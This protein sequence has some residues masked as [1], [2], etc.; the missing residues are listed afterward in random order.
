MFKRIRQVLA[1]ISEGQTL[2]ARIFHGGAWLGAGSLSEQTVRFARNVILARLLAPEAFGTMA[3][4]LSA[5]SIFQSFTD[6]GVKEALIQNPRGAEP[7]YVGAAWW[8]AFGRTLG[9]YS[10][11]FLL[12]PW[13][14]RFYGNAELTVLLRVALFGVLIEGATSAGTFVALKNMRFNKVAAINHGG[15]ICGVVIT[16]ILSFYIRDVWA[17][18]IGFLAENAA[19]CSLSYVLCPFAPPLRWHM[20]AFRDLLKFSRGLFGLSFLNFIYMR[21]DV[22]VLAKLVPAAVLGIYSMAIYVI[23]T[24]TGFVINLLGQIFMPTFSQLQGDKIRTNRAI[25]LTTGI[26]M[27]VGM[28]ALAFTFFCGKSLLALV[29]GRR[30]AAGAGPLMVAACVA[31]INVVNAQITSVFYAAGKPQL[32]RRCVAIMAITMVLLIYPLVKWW[33]LIGAQVACLISITAGFLLQVERIRHITGLRV[34]QFGRVFLL[35][36]T[37]SIGVVIVCLSARP[38]HLLARPLPNIGLGLVGCL[39]AY[40]LACASFFRG[41]WGTTS[42]E[43]LLCVTENVG[44][45]SANK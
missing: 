35:S 6:I 7:E 17:L 32:H 2:K 43:A 9:I 41:G 42:R 4:V 26:V 27:V 5:T 14:A 3:I 36:I 38:F 39:L 20:D 30:Y 22:F 18:V 34:S 23:Q 37:I 12:A 29:Y 31:L 10:V 13:L 24:P 19:R 40:G 21:A 25:F 45:G 44:R 15:G 16:I 28:P 33:G 8:L 1:T 11:V